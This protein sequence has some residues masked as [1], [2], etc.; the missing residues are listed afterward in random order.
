[1]VR[2]RV[3]CSYDRT[4]RCYVKRIEKILSSVV[5][6]ANLRMRVLVLDRR[7]NAV[8]IHVS[9][10]RSYRAVYGT[11]GAERNVAC[12]RR[13]AV[14]RFDDVELNVAVF[15]RYMAVYRLDKLS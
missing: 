5:P 15:I 11:H 12:Y 13:Y 7:E 4:G 6:V 3:V 10:N 1:M 8:K 2:I 14:Y 9:V